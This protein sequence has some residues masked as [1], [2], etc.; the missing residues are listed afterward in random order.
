PP[1]RPKPAA[2]EAPL[3]R[4]IKEPAARAAAPAARE[5]APGPRE[6]AIGID[7]GTT[8][9]VVAYLDAYGRPVSIPNAAGDILTPSVLLVDDG[10]IVV[11]K[12]A[13]QGAALEPAKVAAVVKRDMGSKAYRKKVNGEFMPP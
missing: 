6:V 8:Y 9:S 2:A 13:V 4:A 3:A 12:E 7:L 10:G 1:A 11:G 5:A